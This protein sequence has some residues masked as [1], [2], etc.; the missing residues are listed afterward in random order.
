[1]IRR[2]SSLAAD[3]LMCGM[4]NLLQSRHR[5]DRHSRDQM[6][7]YVVACEKLT[8]QEYYQSGEETDILRQIDKHSIVSWRSPI[9]TEFEANNV[10]RAELFP[11]SEGWTAPTVLMLHALMSASRI[12]YRR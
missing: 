9:K 7:D 1:M 12:G 6:Q 4:M 2:S 5:L 10:A 8:I 3:A 11:C